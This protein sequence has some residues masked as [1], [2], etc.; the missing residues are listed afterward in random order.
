MQTPMLAKNSEARIIQMACM[1]GQGVVQGFEAGVA[2]S[3]GVADVPGAEAQII[4][5][6]LLAPISRR[7]HS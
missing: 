3:S 1:A 7:Y 6:V 4:C 5:V 2:M